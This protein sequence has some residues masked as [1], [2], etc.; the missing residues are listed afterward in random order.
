MDGLL[1]KY[2]LRHDIAEIHGTKHQSI[3]KKYSLSKKL[4]FTYKLMQK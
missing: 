1:Q 2:K 3:D 4:F